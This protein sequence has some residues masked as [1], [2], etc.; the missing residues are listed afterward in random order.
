MEIPAR[1]DCPSVWKYQNT[2][3]EDLLLMV[4]NAYF[5]RTPIDQHYKDNMVIL[6]T[7]DLEDYYQHS[8]KAT[9]DCNSNLDQNIVSQCLDCWL[10]VFEDEMNDLKK[11]KT[12]FS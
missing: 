4:E 1:A 2:I 9:F 8:N 6:M 5:V 3:C 12:R 10:N 11:F 7:V